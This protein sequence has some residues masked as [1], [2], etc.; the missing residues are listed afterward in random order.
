MREPRIQ[1][2]FPAAL[3]CT[4]VHRKINPGGRGIQHGG[5]AAVKSPE[6]S[7]DT[8]PRGVTIF[9]AHTRTEQPHQK[10][11]A[12]VIPSEEGVKKPQRS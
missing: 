6:N 1:R 9:L 5:W 7:T 4:V 12:L 8:F 11:K 3:F 10:Q 2:G